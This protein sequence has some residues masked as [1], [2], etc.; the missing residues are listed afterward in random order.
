MEV[1]SRP[2][3]GSTRWPCRQRRAAL[4]SAVAFVAAGAVLA[5]GPMIAGAATPPPPPFTMCPAVGAGTGCQILI[6]LDADGTRSILADDA[7]LPYEGSKAGL[8]GIQ[9][10]S[11]KT[12]MA[13][14]LTA[15]NSDGGGFE[16]SKGGPCGYVPAPAECATPGFGGPTGYSGPRNTFSDISAD[17]T[18]G[19]INFTGG[20]ANGKSTWFALAKSQFGMTVTAGDPMQASDLAVWVEA[21]PRFTG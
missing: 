5:V 6:V 21:T 3:G 10:N 17:R 1:S 16:F 15:K 9:N 19:T 13:L 14:P 8:I 18:R 20:L 7:Q 2:H 11:G 12:L 4:A